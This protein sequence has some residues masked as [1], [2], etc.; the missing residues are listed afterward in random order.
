MLSADFLERRCHDESLRR[1]RDAFAENIFLTL[2]TINELRYTF[3]V[4]II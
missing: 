3:V 1:T 2:K 4:F